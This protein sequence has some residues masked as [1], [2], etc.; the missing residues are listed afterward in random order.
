VITHFETALAQQ[1][2]ALYP[3]FQD[4]VRMG[5]PFLLRSDIADAVQRFRDQNPDAAGPLSDPALVHWFHQIQEAVVGPT[6]ICLAV[7]TQIARWLYMRIHIDEMAAEN[8]TVQA[9][10]ELKEQIILDPSPYRAQPLELDI[11]P[12]NRDLPAMSKSKSIGRGVEFLN[13]HLA[14]QMFRDREA[15]GNQLLRFLKLHHVDGHSLMLNERMADLMGLEDNLREAIAHV[16]ARSPQTPW[17][18]LATDLQSMGLEPGWGADAGRV[19]DS[20]ELL[21]DLLEAPDAAILERFLSRIPMIFRIAV[22]TPHGWFGQDG[23]LG[24]PDTGGQVVYILDQVRA[25]EAHMTRWLEDQGVAVSPQIVVVTRLIPNS[26]GT[27]SHVRIEKIHG[28]QNARILR[29]PFREPSGEVV[30]NWISRFEVW[31]YLEE[32]ALE[33]EREL[34]AELGQRPDLVIGNYSDGNLVASI[35][36]HRLGV[37]QCNV[38]HALEKSKYVLSDLYWRDNEPKY[39]FSAQFTADLIAMNT[40]DF[41]IASTYQEIAG[42][43]DTV[44]QYESYTHFTMPGLYRVVNG[45]DLFD[46]KFN[47]VSP[48]AS[49]EVYFPYTDGTRRLPALHTE[50]TELMFGDGVDIPHRGRLIDPDKPLILS[51]SRLDRIKN[52]TGLMDAF[53]GSKRLRERANLLIIGGHVDPDTSADAEEADEARLLHELFDRHGLEGQARWLGVHLTKPQAGELYRLVADR[54]GVFVQPALFEAF[55]LTVVEA[56]VSGLPTFATWYGGPLE[57]VEDGLSGFHVDPTHPEEMADRIAAFFEE[58]ARNPER[59][60]EVS[61]A[62]IARVHSRYTWDLYAER[63]LTLSKVYGFWRFVS[64]LERRETVRYLEM[65]Y[66]LQFR[67]LAARV[68]GG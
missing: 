20:L 64:D 37:T 51:M 45:I 36:A 49:A 56:M 66:H 29:V 28:C 40:A 22:I 33:A 41:I 60:E 38:A 63:L 10:L 25:L 9:Y 47:I 16:Q 57:I 59:W 68:R 62:G 32:F 50:L 58:V 42:T 26:E 52:L 61:G 31:P 2:D 5:R 4:L 53:G 35:L 11:G 21:A 18:E 39:H 54:R 46:P 15:A 44:G 13:R 1:R 67:P 8:L 19:R 14:S 55:G 3:L 23:V 27:C 6:W 34:L 30:P 17:S 24:R 48:G 43:A 12:F 65:F 7:R